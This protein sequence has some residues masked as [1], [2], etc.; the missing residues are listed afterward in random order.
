M[1]GTTPT[2]TQ[3]PGTGI[4]GEYHLLDQGLKPNRAGCEKSY[5][6]VRERGISAAGMG[7]SADP[8]YRDPLI[9]ER[10]RAAGA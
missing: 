3:N 6:F 5:Q 7:S 1:G 9:R 8:D 10:G 4:N 2:L